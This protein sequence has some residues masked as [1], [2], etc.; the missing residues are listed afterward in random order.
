MKD[1]EGETD[2][3]ELF[4]RNKRRVCVLCVWVLAAQGFQEPSLYSLFLFITPLLLPASITRS[5]VWVCSLLSFSNLPPQ[6]VSAATMDTAHT[7]THTRTLSSIFLLLS[8]T[9]LPSFFPF[10]FFPPPL[11]PSFSSCSS[12]SSSPPP[13]HPSTPLQPYLLPPLLIKLPPCPLYLPLSAHLPKLHSK[14]R[15]RWEQ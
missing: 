2:D 5:E 8:S 10:F 15:R 12:S 3:Q 14:H 4:G 9:Q 1:K 6:C 11:L 13:L 7:H